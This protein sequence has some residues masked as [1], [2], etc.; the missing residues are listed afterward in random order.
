MR[1]FNCYLV[2]IFFYAMPMMAA[3]S[4]EPITLD[5]ASKAAGIIAGSQQRLLT[6]GIDFNAMEKG[7]ADAYLNKPDEQKIMA[8][9]KAADALSL[10]THTAKLI[11]KL[12][13]PARESASYSL[14]ILMAVDARQ[15]FSLLDID[16][17]MNGF[18][19]A[20]K[21]NMQSTNIAQATMVVS[22]YYRQER[23]ANADAQLKRST[24][25][26]AENTNRPGIKI[27]GSGLQYEVLIQGKG[28]RPR[29]V[30]SVKV[31]YRHSKPDSNF[32]YD[33]AEKGHSEIIPLRGAIPAGWRELFLLMQP[34][35]KYRVYLSPAL[36]F[37]EEGNGENLL[38]N[39]VLISEFTLLEIV[40]PTA[41]VND[42][43]Q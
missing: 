35:A 17:Y 6:A 20:Y 25:F 33:S 1:L 15:Q 8:E 11:H 4:G 3:T 41:V 43:W 24:A 9:K 39:E 29:I 28:D 14:G 38:P 30:D 5:H 23:L 22:H 18:K 12:G 42:P 21:R 27:T 32:Y 26:L 40:P 16:E 7:L 37:G 19:T 36:G 34:G 31:N 10:S 13:R 2:L